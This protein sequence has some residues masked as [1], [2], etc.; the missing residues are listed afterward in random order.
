MI[1]N[2]S[3]G[4]RLLAALLAFGAAV[5]PLGAAP[6]TASC[7][8]FEAALGEGLLDPFVDEADRER[9][10][11]R[12]LM[13]AE[14]GCPFAVRVAAGLHALGDAHP[15][16]LLPKDLD[17]AER[18]FLALLETGDLAMFGRLSDLAHARGDWEQ[19][20]GWAQL[21]GRSATTVEQRR[22]RSS[23]PEATRLLALFEE[24]PGAGEAEAKAA[25]AVVLAEHGDAIRTGLAAFDAARAPSAAAD[26]SS[27]ELVADRRN[28]GLLARAPAPRTR[29][30]HVQ[31]VLAIDAE[32]RVARRWWYD[33]TPDTR[34][35]EAFGP[36]V[37][38]FRFNPAPGAAIRWAIQ[39]L[40]LNDGAI[41]LG[42]DTPS[43]TRRPRDQDGGPL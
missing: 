16:R 37:D 25:V 14:A 27:P 24:R 21:A 39:P 35:A 8:T 34:L 41:G 4:I 9:K 36:I 29:R 15:A 38:R 7:E 42:E 32:G 22:G 43:L 13:S 19:A 26:E 33:A 23:G 3:M 11:G 5:S 28:H 18:G 6:T 1:E 40:V 30:A 2:C 12:L 10:A 20:M 31:F 17:A